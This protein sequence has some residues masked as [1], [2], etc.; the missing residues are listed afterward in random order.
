MILALLISADIIRPSMS[1]PPD[2]IGYKTAATSLPLYV[3][4]IINMQLNLRSE[5]LRMDLGR[6]HCHS[7]HLA[8]TNLL[9]AR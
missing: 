5:E 4:S 1:I 2:A 7:D 3:C 6:R 8:D 9:L